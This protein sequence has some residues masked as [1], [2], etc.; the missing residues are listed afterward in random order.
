MQEI[1]YCMISNACNKTICCR[2]CNENA[3]N[4]R[5]FE[6]DKECIY[7]SENDEISMRKQR[8]IENNSACQIKSNK[9]NNQSN[10]SDYKQRMIDIISDLHKGRSAKDLS[11]KYN[12]SLARIYNIRKSI[13]KGNE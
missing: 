8:I 11:K 2:F 12:L 6:K 3:C 7:L 5:C 9:L 10:K 4:N 13:N 1:K